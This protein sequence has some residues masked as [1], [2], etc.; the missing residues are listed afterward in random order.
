MDD[1]PNELLPLIFK[2]LDLMDLPNCR[3]VRNLRLR[4]QWLVDRIIFSFFRYEFQVERRWTVFIDEVK[5]RE[6]IVSADKMGC[7]EVWYNTKMKT[8]ARNKI[9]FSAIN[10]CPFDLAH[11]QRLKIVLTICVDTFNLNGLLATFSQLNLLHISG[12]QT[13][14]RLNNVSITLPDSLKTI[15]LNDVDENLKFHLNASKLETVYCDSDIRNLKFS[16]PESVKHLKFEYYNEIRS[17]DNDDVAVLPNLE[18]FHCVWGY[19]LADARLDYVKLFPKLKQIRF[20][21][22][23]IEQYNDYERLNSLVNKILSQKK[24]SLRNNMK[25][26]CDGKEMTR[27]NSFIHYHLSGELLQ[28]DSESDSDT[29]FDMDFDDLSSDSDSEFI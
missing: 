20:E 21:T 8:N 3:L 1:L 23:G 12:I 25:I 26:Y 18:Y 6:L 17:N 24:V 4:Y 28:C 19:S 14:Q 15:S 29:H 22:E 11:V 16:H 7:S 9:T 10:R 27:Y 5:L 2:H 13:S